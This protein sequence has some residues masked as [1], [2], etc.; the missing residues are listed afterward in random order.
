MQ[1]ASHSSVAFTRGTTSRSDVQQIKEYECTGEAFFDSCTQRTV[2]T[3]NPPGAPLTLDLRANALH[4]RSAL[5]EQVIDEC[6]V[7]GVNTSLT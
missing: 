4:T 1:D 7:L 3:S 5:R 6:M 2:R